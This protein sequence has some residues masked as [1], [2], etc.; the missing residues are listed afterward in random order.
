[1]KLAVM[2]LVVVTVVVVV[3]VKLGKGLWILVSFFTASTPRPN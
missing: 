1:M 3:V 2:V